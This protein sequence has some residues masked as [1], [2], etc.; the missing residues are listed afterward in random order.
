M[1]HT[2]S[3]FSLF[4]DKVSFGVGVSESVSGHRRHA[5]RFVSSSSTPARYP[6]LESVL[7]YCFPNFIS[8]FAANLHERSLLRFRPPRPYVASPVTLHPAPQSRATP[9]RAPWS[10]TASRAAGGHSDAV[11]VLPAAAALVQPSRPCPSPAHGSPRL[12]VAA[13]VSRRGP[14]LPLLRS[15]S[16]STFLEMQTQGRRRSYL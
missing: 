10:A 12:R 13:P 5:A 16:T 9:A 1:C 15:S 3:C 4:G 2:E 14:S 7:V 6:F 11:Q 8:C